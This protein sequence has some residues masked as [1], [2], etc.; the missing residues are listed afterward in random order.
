MVGSGSGSRSGWVDVRCVAI[1]G[2]CIVVGPL[3]RVIE[4]SKWVQRT[5]QVV[6]VVAIDT[7]VGRIRV[8]RG[9]V[10]GGVSLRVQGTGVVYRRLV[11]TYPISYTHTNADASKPTVAKAAS[12]DAGGC[13][14]IGG[15]AGIGEEATLSV[16]GIIDVLVA[17]LWVC[18]HYDD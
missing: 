2:Y 9:I 13:G 15:L 7:S 14:A 18:F 16:S 6:V 17:G 5:I 4:V 3:V 10:V 1:S 11:S 8:I 12:N